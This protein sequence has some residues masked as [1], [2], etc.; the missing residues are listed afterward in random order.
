MFR[1]RLE[2]LE[3]VERHLGT[4]KKEDPWAA[5]AARLLGSVQIDDEK[6]ESY[7]DASLVKG[8]K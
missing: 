7:Y 3:R 4:E 5:A 8:R 1:R 2:R 6:P